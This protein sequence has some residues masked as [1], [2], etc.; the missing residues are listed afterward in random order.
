MKENVFDVAIIG[1]GVAGVFAA[2]KLSQASDVRCI[3]FDLGRP[4]GKRR[5]QLSG[6]FGCFPNSDGKLYSQDV[7]K[8]AE[9]SGKRSAGKAATWVKRYINDVTKVKLTED[10]KPLVAA[11]KRIQKAGF[12]YHL[13]DYIQMFPKDIHAVSKCLSDEIETSGKVQFSFDNEVYSIHKQKGMFCLVTE[14]GEFQAK[15]ILITV[16][17]SGWRWA[18]KIYE[19][20]GIVD[21]DEVARFG[22]HAEIS[23]SYMKDFNKSNLSMFNNDMTIGPVSWNGTIIPEDHYDLA[24]SAF[25]SNENRWKTDKVSFKIIGNYATAKGSSETN[26]LGCLA[27]VLA[28]ERISKERISTLVGG[29][30]KVSP[31]REFDWLTQACNKIQEVIPEFINKG[32]FHI[33]TIMPLPPKVALGDNFSTELDNFFL[34]GESAGVHGLMGAAVSGALAADGIVK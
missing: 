1:G 28:N 10:R 6:W 13:N 23:S 20:F 29:R 15:K 31:L 32:Y 2:K 26:R 27:F 22:V 34:A 24:I 5:H 12:D 8:V 4:Q 19:N 30:S 33:P 7:E 11:E 3:L 18:T 17:R 25:R 14:Q 9:T 21:S 16:G